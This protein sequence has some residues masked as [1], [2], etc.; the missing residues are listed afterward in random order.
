M[1]TAW[2][3]G[4]RFTSSIRRSTPPASTPTSPW[5]LGDPITVLA[6]MMMTVQMEGA[7]LRQNTQSS[8]HMA[9][10]WN[11]QSLWIIV[12]IYGSQFV[13]CG[14][15]FLLIIRLVDA[16]PQMP[17]HIH[18]VYRPSDPMNKV[19]AKKVRKE[20]NELEILKLLNAT[21]PKSDHVIS[22]LDSFQ[23]PSRTW[24]ILPKMVS[25]ADCVEFAPEELESKVVQVCLGL[26]E[27]LAYLHRF[28]IA[29]RDIKPHNLLV[30]SDFCLKI[31]DFDIA[32]QVKDEDEEV[33]DQCGT[34]GWIAPE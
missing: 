11:Q 7:N 20:S 15:L 16:P 1:K 2:T 6:Q 12:V 30:D 32:M 28:C 25:I 3:R 23:G 4:T 21:Q 31:I 27:G 10:R 19:I 26:I 22:L 9:T 5:A 33:A 24:A 29:H 13:G 17:P 14:N 8:E 18:I 34:K